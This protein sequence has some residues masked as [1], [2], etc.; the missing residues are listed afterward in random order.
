MISP[1]PRTGRGAGG[2]GQSAFNPCPSAAIHIRSRAYSLSLSLTRKMCSNMVELTCYNKA[3]P[4][5]TDTTKASKYTAADIQVLE[6][7]EDVRRRPSMYIGSTDDRGLH[8]LVYEILHNSI[9]EA[10]AGFCNRI[11]ITIREDCRGVVE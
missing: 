1:R 3:S 11:N 2:E 5:M 8:H 10:M 9:D 7:L 6:G 4:R